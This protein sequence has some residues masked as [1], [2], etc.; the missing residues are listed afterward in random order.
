[1]YPKKKIILLICPNDLVYLQY[2]RISS[3]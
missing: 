3:R 1:L 2:S